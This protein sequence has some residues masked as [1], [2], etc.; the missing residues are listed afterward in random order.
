MDRCEYYYK[1]GKDQNCLA[2]ASSL[3]KDLSGH[4][5]VRGQ[6]FTDNGAFVRIHNHL[7]SN[8]TW[9]SVSGWDSGIEYTIQHPESDIIV[10]DT[11]RGQKTV[12]FRESVLQRAE[13]KAV[14]SSTSFVVKKTLRNHLD[15]T[16]RSYHDSIH[17]WVKIKSE[18]VFVYESQRSSW[19]FEL[20][21]VW[22]GPTKKQAEDSERKFSVA[23]SLGSVEK[24]SADIFYTT[25]SFLEKM[26]DALQSCSNSDCH[27]HRHVTLAFEEK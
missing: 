10:S 27:R 26:M 2:R 6:F 18:K 9:K 13:G 21:V 4:T 20:A 8:S 15:G 7:K 22:E 14:R 11:N 24:A 12:V 23:V 1:N 16:S 17:T 5:G 19:N 25:A 3:F